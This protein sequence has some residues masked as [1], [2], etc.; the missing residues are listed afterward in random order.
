MHNAGTGL[1]VLPC[2]RGLLT[3]YSQAESRSNARNIGFQALPTPTAWVQGVPAVS[4]TLFNVE[5]SRA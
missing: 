4:E 1:F 5:S 3:E 2:Q